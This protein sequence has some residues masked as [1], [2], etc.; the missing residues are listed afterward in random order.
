MMEDNNELSRRN[1]VRKLEKY[2]SAEKQKLGECI[3]M[4]KKEYDAQVEC[5]KGK[6]RYDAKPKKFTPQGIGNLCWTFIAT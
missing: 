5:L 3:E 6:S 4:F 2:T 1:F